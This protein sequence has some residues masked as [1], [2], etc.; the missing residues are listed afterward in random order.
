M[1]TDEE[2]SVVALAGRLGHVI[3]LLKQLPMNLPEP[4]LGVSPAAG[5]IL[6]WQ[7]DDAA[8]AL[9]VLYAMPGE[10]TIRLFEPLQTVASIG[11]DGVGVVIVVD[12]VDLVEEGIQIERFRKDLDAWTGEGLPT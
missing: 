4:M 5:P 7:L 10:W 2:T 1:S 12:G 9:D 6:R 11:I 8:D 3:D